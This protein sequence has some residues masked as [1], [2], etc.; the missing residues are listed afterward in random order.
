MS[1]GTNAHANPVSGNAQGSTGSNSSVGGGSNS[2][3]GGRG[4][5]DQHYNSGRG[6]GRRN[7]ANNRRNNN[8]GGQPTT[9][10]KY[11]GKC[12]DIADFVYDT[13]ITDDSKELFKNTTRE[14]AEYISRNYDKA[15]DF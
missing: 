14:I 1:E 10:S 3:T 6:S 8:K 12:E 13:G 2:S 5:S 7:R 9:R 11:K 15:G 4:S